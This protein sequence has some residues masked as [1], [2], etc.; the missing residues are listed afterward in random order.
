M[1]MET[2]AREGSVTCAVEKQ[3]E[4]EELLTELGKL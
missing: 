4:M 1:E 2:A 3:Q